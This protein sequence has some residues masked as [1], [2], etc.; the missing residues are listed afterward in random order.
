MKPGGTLAYVT[1]SALPE[2]NDRQI[3]IFL[4]SNTG[5]VT[6]DAFERASQI[7]SEPLPYPASTSAKFGLLLTPA[8]C[9]A[10]GFYVSLLGGR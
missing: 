10:D 4:E 9:N 1:C 8:L 6:L 3:E 5:F 7:L 2:E